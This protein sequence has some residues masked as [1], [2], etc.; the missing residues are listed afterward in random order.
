MVV[1]AKFGGEFK[2]IHTMQKSKVS[3]VEQ[4]AQECLTDSLSMFSRSYNLN[5]NL[6][7]ANIDGTISGSTSHGKAKNAKFKKQKTRS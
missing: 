6:I 3:S 5:A 4:F 1:S 7:V 2:I